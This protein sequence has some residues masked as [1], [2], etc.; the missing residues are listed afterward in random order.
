MSFPIDPVRRVVEREFPTVRSFG[1]YNRRYIAGT[2]QWSQHSWGAAWDIRPPA[3]DRYQV[4]TGSKVFP[5]RRNTLDD[6]YAFLIA[7]RNRGVTF[8]GRRIGNVLWRVKNHY[9]HIHVE[10]SPKFTGVPPLS[11]PTKDDEMKILDLQKALNK[12]GIRDKDGRHLSEDGVYG[13]STES[14][15][16]KAFEG[17]V[18]A[19]GGLA[20][21]VERAFES[22]L[23]T[24]HTDPNRQVTAAEVAAFLERV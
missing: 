24:A 10:L 23:F 11:P 16:V 12:A 17:R 15:L 14:A 6:V 20:G 22:G 5:I 13:S 18:G 1:V 7:Q 19:P 21:V 3:S 9:D 8:G 2:R 4:V